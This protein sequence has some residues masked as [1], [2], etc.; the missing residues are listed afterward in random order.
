[1]EHQQLTLSIT[2]R[3]DARFANY[4]AGPNEQVVQALQQQWTTH[5]E[6]YIYLWGSEGVGC[7]HLLQ[8]ACH[9]AEGL[10]HQGV[11]LPLD[12]LVEYSPAVLDSMEN[13][14]LVALDNVQ[15][16]AGNKEWEEGL[17]H[18]FNRVRDRQGHM[19]IAA[20][21]AP[22]H[23][24]IQLPDLSSRLS[25]GMVYQVE[26]LEDDD[27]IL[28]LLLRAKRRGL[29]MNDDVARF[30]LSRG[31]RDMQ[32]LFDLLDKLDQA[33]LSAQRKLTIPFIKAEM[34]W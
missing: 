33:S 5:G 6:P 3:D 16:V 21:Q 26:P 1:M 13:L 34:E 9:Y 7:S 12:E 32:G 28:A 18:L 14:P 31:P 17:F 2:V 27:K 15:S 30:I 10:G 24:G 19:L 29:N 4:Y 22:N 11:Y 25:W 8:A 23:V 20:N